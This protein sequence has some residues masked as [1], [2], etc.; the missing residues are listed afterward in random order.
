MTQSRSFTDLLT[1][2]LFA[3]VLYIGLVPQ[4]Y[5]QAGLPLWTKYSA[6]LYW[7]GQMIAVDGNDNVF[8]G[9]TALNNNDYGEIAVIAYSSTGNLLW[10]RIN[11]ALY[12]GHDI[13]TAIATAIACDSTGNVFILG[14]TSVNESQS[15]VSSRDLDYV[16]LAYSN[17]GELLWANYYSGTGLLDNPGGIAVNTAGDVFVTG[18]SDNSGVNTS[19][20]LATIKYSGAGV[21]IWTNRFPNVATD[22]SGRLDGS[23]IAVDKD[24][25]VFVTGGAA[26]VAYSSAGS[27]LWTNSSPVGKTSVSNKPGAG[28]L[29]VDNYGKVFVSSGLSTLA[30]SALSG[31]PLWTNRYTDKTYNSSSAIAVDDSGNVVVT[32]ASYESE[33]VPADYLTLAYSNSGMP[34]WTNRYDGPAPNEDSPFG[35]A[36]DSR[37]NA[38]VTGGSWKARRSGAEAIVTLAY[39]P[40]GAPLWTNRFN[41]KPSDSDEGR[42]IAVDSNGNV[43]VAGNVDAIGVGDVTIKYSAIPRSAPA[44]EIRRVDPQLVLTWQSSTFAL[45]AAPSI[46]GQFTTLPGITSPY[47]NAITD[48]QHYFRL[49]GP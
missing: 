19:Y 6:V 16:T 32:G 38:F 21:P 13:A 37:G 5:S 17:K 7:G 4:S 22:V 3:A 28:L 27:M 30:L 42:A 29:A 33:N 34:L 14:Y 8:V 35:L 24:G 44:I 39:S 18:V 45:E 43:I 10:Q 9:G 20:D 23:H 46:T 11:P 26:I 2:A 36:I 25:T 47:T 41:G 1:K 48:T 15:D 31:E 40:F 12:S 49:R